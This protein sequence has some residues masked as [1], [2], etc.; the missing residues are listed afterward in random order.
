[1]ARPSAFPLE[2]WGEPGDLKQ[3]DIAWWLPG[4]AE[5][6]QL[7]RIVDTFLQA[8][9]VRLESFMAGT[10]DLAKEELYRALKTVSS[11]IVGCS[12]VLPAW[13]EEAICQLETKVEHRPREHVVAC[14]SW[15]YRLAGENTRLQHIAVQ[16]NKY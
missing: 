9:L 8:Q 16:V 4:Q 12:A 7:T 3:L 1:M 6:S 5:F 2:D 15:D 13:R 10:E 14:Q 11:I